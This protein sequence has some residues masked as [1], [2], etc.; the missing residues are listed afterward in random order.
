MYDLWH[1]NV[2]PWKTQIIFKLKASLHYPYKQNFGIDSNC[3][4]NFRVIL[5]EASIIE[6]Y[7]T[8]ED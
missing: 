4:N 3:T 5:D 7:A 2:T 8:N 6:Y 1:K